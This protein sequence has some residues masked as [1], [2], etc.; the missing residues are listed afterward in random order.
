MSMEILGL[1]FI[2]I[3]AIVSIFF[4]IFTI[5]ILTYFKRINEESL[6]LSKR[7]GISFYKITEQMTEEEVQELLKKYGMA[8]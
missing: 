8:K 3:V 2:I 1:V 6:E 4:L 5:G 7:S